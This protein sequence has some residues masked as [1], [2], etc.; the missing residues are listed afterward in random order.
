MKTIRYFEIR[1]ID[2]WMRNI[3]VSRVTE[4]SRAFNCI[5]EMGGAILNVRWF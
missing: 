4:L 5:N 3:V 1:W 2:A